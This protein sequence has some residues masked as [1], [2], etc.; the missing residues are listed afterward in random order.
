MRRLPFLL[1]STGILLAA[2]GVALVLH[3]GIS[4]HTAVTPVRHRHPRRGP[5][6]SQPRPQP[7]PRIVHGP[8][9]DPVPILMYHV[10]SAPKLGAPYPELYTP[11]PVFAAQMSALAGRG[12][13]GVSLGQVDDYWRKGYALPR[14]PVVVSFDDGYLSDFTHA[15]PVL[16]RLR[17]PGVLNLAVKNVT[18][19]DLTANQV[20]AL[21]SA[22]WEVDSHTINHLDLTLVSDAQLRYEVVASRAY[23]RHRFGVPATFF[24]YPSGRYDARVVAAVKAAG[25]RAATTTHSGLASPASPFALSRIRVT[26]QDGAS[27]LLYKLAHPGAAPSSYAGG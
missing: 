13:H 15:L 17:W 7:P 19:G 10:V 12:Y 16:R 3:G 4:R 24:C 5:G 26:G 21:I 6:A 25:Y 27:G 22:G 9:R 8:H 2:L 11:E 18:P 23:I 20:R 1:A 14:H